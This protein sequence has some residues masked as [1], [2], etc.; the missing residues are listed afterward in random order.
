MK[1]VFVDRRFF[2]IDDPATVRHG[3]ELQ[4][5]MMANADGMVKREFLIKT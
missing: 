1:D 3:D 2:Q 4:L 5:N